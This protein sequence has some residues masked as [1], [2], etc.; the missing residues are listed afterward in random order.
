MQ[1]GEQEVDGQIE[2]QEGQ[3]PIEGAERDSGDTGGQGKPQKG[4]W[5][6][7]HRFDEV[8]QG[9]TKYKEF[10]K[11]ED[12]AK[13]LARLKELEALPQNRTT[14]KEKSE[15]RKELLNVFPELQ[16][17]SNMLEVQKQ[18][19]TARGAELNNDFLK[20]LGIEVNEPNNQYLQELLSGIIAADQKLLRRFYAMD[21][22]VFESAFAVAKKTFWPNVRKIVP[23]AGVQAKKVLPKAPDKQKTQDEPNGKK[24]GG[25]LGRLE[26][27]D[28]LDKASEAAFAMLESSRSE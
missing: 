24:P 20:E 11:P 27:R 21:P 12:I 26:E 18:V 13:N 5:I 14:D 7:K 17:M 1:D 3:P 2:G 9:Y 28:E 8:N 10:G 23:G 22:K 15:I 6:P 4:E 16:V 19:Y 25:Q